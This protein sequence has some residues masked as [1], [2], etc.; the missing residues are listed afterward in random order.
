MMLES[1][2]FFRAY[3]PVLLSLQQLSGDKLGFAEQFST[4]R[5]R[6]GPPEYIRDADRNTLQNA[7]ATAMAGLDG[8]QREVR[9]MMHRRQ[10]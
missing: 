1:T 7:L 6:R 4:V 10:L 2:T 9:D 3:G 8:T 5:P